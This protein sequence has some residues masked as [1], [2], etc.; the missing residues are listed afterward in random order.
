MRCAV[1]KSNET[2]KESKLNEKQKK[3]RE[4]LK[5]FAQ[6]LRQL[7]F[8][9]SPLSIKLAVYVASAL[10]SY[11]KG[12]V[13]TLETAFGLNAGKGTKGYK[14]DF[15]RQRAEL[16][17]A[18]RQNGKTWEKIQEEIGGKYGLP[19]DIRELQ[20][21]VDEFRVKILSEGITLEDLLSEDD[22]Q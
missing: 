20:R 7:Q 16:I 2:Q 19:N 10:E 12:E 9:T 8:P 1:T 5:L 4:N 17:I 13:K 18:A 22:D 15:N 14:P 6:Q 3:N 21:I 11:L